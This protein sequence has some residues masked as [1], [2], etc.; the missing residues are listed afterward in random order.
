MSHE[1]VFGVQILVQPIP[2]F[3]YFFDHM[4]AAEIRACSHK[5][6]VLHVKVNV[7][8]SGISD[9]P[10]GRT[11]FALQFLVYVRTEAGNPSSRGN[12][13]TNGLRIRQTGMKKSGAEA[14]DA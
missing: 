5:K 6:C 2:I 7:L 9:Q 11:G 14:S 3:T 1:E 4:F 8:R 13:R 12:D 10:L